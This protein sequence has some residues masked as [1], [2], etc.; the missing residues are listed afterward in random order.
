MKEARATKSFS[1]FEL[2][3]SVIAFVPNVN[4]L[5]PP[6]HQAVAAAAGGTDSLKNVGIARDLLRHASL[7]LAANASVR[8]PLRGCIAG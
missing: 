6:I 8:L 5:V 3:S 2:L 1:S 7:G 4:L